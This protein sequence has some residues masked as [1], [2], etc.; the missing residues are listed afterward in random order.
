MFAKCRVQD[1]KGQEKGTYDLL[2]GADP[3][4][5]R[6]S[7]SFQKVPCRP[8]PVVLHQCFGLLAC[9]CVTLWSFSLSWFSVYFMIHLIPLEPQVKL[10][11]S[12][13]NQEILKEL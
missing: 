10:E 6:V 11:G 2:M 5:G 3:E 4:R 8:S 9:C 13:M 12:L 7:P 1:L